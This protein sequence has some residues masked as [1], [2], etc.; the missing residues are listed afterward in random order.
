MDTLPYNHSVDLLNKGGLV[1]SFWSLTVVVC[2]INTILWLTTHFSEFKVKSSCENSDML[3]G[4]YRHRC[5]PAGLNNEHSLFL[6]KKGFLLNGLITEGRRFRGRRSRRSQSQG[7]EF[8]WYSWDLMLSGRWRPA[9][10]LWNFFAP[11]PSFL[12][13]KRRSFPVASS[14]HCHFYTHTQTHRVMMNST[15]R[16]FC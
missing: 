13:L 16:E 1:H 4:R 2:R 5:P 15:G 14:T 12:H 7:S 3:P 8:R 9:A 6:E 10:P 11:P